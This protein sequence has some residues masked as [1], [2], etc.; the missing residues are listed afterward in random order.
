ML[1]SKDLTAHAV[2]GMHHC[3]ARI[4]DHRLPFP[5]TLA[6][7]LLIAQR[8][9]SVRRGLQ[10]PVQGLCLV[11]AERMAYKPHRSAHGADDPASFMDAL[12]QGAR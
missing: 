4:L 1:S 5:D 12:G 8:R 3:W 6:E 11:L 7:G 10:L 2:H 9:Q